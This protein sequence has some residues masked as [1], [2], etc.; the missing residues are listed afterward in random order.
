MDAAHII[1]ASSEFCNIAYGP[2]CEALGKML[3]AGATEHDG[4]GATQL[5]NPDNN[6]NNGGL[7]CRAGQ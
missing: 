5:E 6:S 1:I 3:L 2:I 7:G 4:C